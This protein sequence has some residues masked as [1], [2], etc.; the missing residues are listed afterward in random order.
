[1]KN[2]YN[3]NKN[4]NYASFKKNSKQETLIAVTYTFY[5]LIDFKYSE[6][7]SAHVEFSTFQ[8]NVLPYGVCP[9]VTSVVGLSFSPM[10]LLV[11]HAHQ[12]F[13]GLVLSANF[14]PEH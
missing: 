4:P 10:Y 11:H 1:M 12:H 7:D 8:K 9:G 3:V 13:I 5:N 14:P 6:V 2:R